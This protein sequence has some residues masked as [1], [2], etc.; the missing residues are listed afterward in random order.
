MRIRRLLYLAE[1]LSGPDQS[2]ENNTYLVLEIQA[3]RPRAIWRYLRFAAREW[4]YEFFFRLE[5]RALLFWYQKIKGLSLNAAIEQAQKH[6][7]NH[8]FD[9]SMKGAGNGKQH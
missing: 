8:I 5:F 9:D 3:S 2:I 7:E 1:T 4:R 6:I